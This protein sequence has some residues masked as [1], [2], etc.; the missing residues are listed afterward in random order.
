QPHEALTLG[1]LWTL[2][3]FAQTDLL[4]LH[5]TGVA[6]YEAGFTQSRTQVFVILH[7]G[8]GQ[9]MANGTGLTEAATTTHSHFN[10]ELVNQINVF[11]RLANHHARYLTTKVLVQRAIVH[12]DHTGTSSN[13]YA[14]G[15]GLAATS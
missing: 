8:T 5:F 1:V 11:Q 6:S 13:K 4:T 7:Q 15:R 9:T 14:S 12:G 2:A 3:R 10:V